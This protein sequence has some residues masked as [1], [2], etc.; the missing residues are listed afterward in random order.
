MKNF[1]IFYKKLRKKKS[2]LNP[3]RFSS[4]LGILEHFWKKSK[5]SKIG[6]KSFQGLLKWKIS[7]WNKAIFLESSG[8]IWFSAKS[9]ICWMGF[10]WFNARIMK[11]NKVCGY[12][13]VFEYKLAVVVIFCENLAFSGSLFW[14]RNALWCSYHTA[15]LVESSRCSSCLVL[16]QNWTFL[17][18]SNLRVSRPKK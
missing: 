8:I 11:I 15:H 13:T 7:A 12:P 17:Q 3:W 10:R 9:K 5:R 16:H 14:C 6:P 1:N 18:R 2:I 4:H